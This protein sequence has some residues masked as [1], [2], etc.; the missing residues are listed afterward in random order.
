[1]FRG[2][3][4][5]PHQE[6]ECIYVANST[7]YTSKLTESRP[8]QLGSRPRRARTIFHIRHIYILPPDGGLLIRLKH[9]GV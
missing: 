7:C 4:A 8:G 9:V 3:S 5:A 6:A 2:V 1:M